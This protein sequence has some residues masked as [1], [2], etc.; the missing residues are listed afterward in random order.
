MR[1]IPV[2][3]FLL[4]LTLL[5]AA[6]C[7]VPSL[8]AADNRQDAIISPVALTGG[9]ELNL[10]SSG[11]Q[12]QATVAD[13]ALL[14]FEISSSVLSGPRV[15]TFGKNNVPSDKRVKFTELPPGSYS[16]KSMAKDAA[17]ETIGSKTATV[18]VE[19]GKTAVVQLSLK[20]VATEITNPNGNLYIDFEMIDGDVVVK[21]IEE[22][23]PAP[24]P[25]PTASATP[26]PHAGSL[27]LYNLSE[28]KLSNGRYEAKGTV[29]NSATASLTGEIKA[30]FKEYKGL[31]NRRL[32]V[33]ETKVLPLAIGAKATHDFTMTSTEKADAVSVTISVK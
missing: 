27:G 28:S 4:P 19:A 6:G 3:S 33:V 7:G 26:N 13:V 24:T 12:T 5:A 18:T 21:P 32:E 17:G 10:A 9:L 23:S 15:Q 22:P 2:L 11:F 16:V 20:L 31:F 14:E 25:T 1:F 8:T 30:E 29:Y